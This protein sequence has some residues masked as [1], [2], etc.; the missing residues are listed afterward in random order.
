MTNVVE[1]RGSR[2]RV[3][4]CPGVPLGTQVL[5]R[6]SGVT[7]DADRSLVQSRPNIADIMER[8]RV[9]GQISF[10]SRPPLVEGSR[11]HVT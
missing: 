1:G 5:I 6:C 4:A 3:A 11:F 9:D 8:K 7:D 2:H 10:R